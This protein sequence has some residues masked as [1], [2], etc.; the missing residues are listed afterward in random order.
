MIGWSEAESHRAS[1]CLI[2]SL[3]AFMRAANR[4]LTVFSFP[5]GMWTGS[6]CSDASPRSTRLRAASNLSAS[7]VQSSSLSQ[8]PSIRSCCRAAIR[9]RA[10][11]RDCSEPRGKY[12]S[13]VFAAVAGSKGLSARSVRVS[14]IDD[15]ESVLRIEAGFSIWLVLTIRLVPGLLLVRKDRLVFRH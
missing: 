7:P 13:P 6:Q 15:C 3:A 4:P 14:F 12:P 11:A 1:Y 5:G 2:L 8:S 10:A 9:E